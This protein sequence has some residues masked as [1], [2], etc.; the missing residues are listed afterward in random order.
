MLHRFYLNNV[1]PT[2][3]ISPGKVFAVHAVGWCRALRGEAYL[4]SVVGL[5]QG[6]H[7]RH[8]PRVFVPVNSIEHIDLH[9]LVRPN[10]RK[11]HACTFIAVAFGVQA[12][13]YLTRV[14]YQLDSAVCRDGQF[15][16]RIFIALRPVRSVAVRQDEH[17]DFPANGLL[18]PQ[19]LGAGGGEKR[20]IAVQFPEVGN[21]VVKRP[22]GAY[23][24]LGLRHILKAYTGFA[25][26]FFPHPQSRNAAHV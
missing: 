4:I 26:Q 13:Q 5:I 20:D 7:D 17:P 9:S 3:R 11:D 23:L 15:Q 19:L 25:S 12:P 24:L 8:D 1:V 22:G 14:F 2:G 6:V 16:Q 10:I 21:V 18:L